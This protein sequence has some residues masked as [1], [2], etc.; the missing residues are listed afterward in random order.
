MTAPVVE[1]RDLN[2]RFFTYYGVVR[3]VNGVTFSV[4]GEETLGIVGESGSGK[5]VTA[6]SMMGLIEPPGYVAGGEILFS[7]RDLTRI[8]DDEWLRL[9][10]AEITMCFQNPMRA[11]N[12]VMKLG[13]QLARVHMTHNRSSV[14]EATER[15]VTLLKEVNIAD[16]ER[17]MGRYPHQLSGGM[18]QRV[19]TVM[20]MICEPRVLI[21]DEPT[22]GLDVTVQKQLL[23]LLRD[24]RER[25]SASQM[26]ITHDLGVVANI[27][28]RVVV[29]YGGRV[30]ETAG[31]EAIFDNPRHPYTVALLDAIP[32]VD[33]QTDLT[34][35]PGTVPEPL[36][37]PSGCP[38]HPRCTH[39][40]PICSEDMPLL[41][42]VAEGQLAACHLFS[43]EGTG[44]ATS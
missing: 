10:G 14:S 17:L 16:A 36:H 28:D 2:V 4:M 11:L 30:M 39:A 41:F 42:D 40:M 6:L 15:A 37:L 7:G 34:P 13:R 21:L 27:C 19:M 8:S 22:T 12:P 25:T 18:C 24:L 5:S 33:S 3:A 1:I 35:I 32:Q 26:L 29:M 44:V 43:K 31:V 20:A 9:R 23:H 38:F